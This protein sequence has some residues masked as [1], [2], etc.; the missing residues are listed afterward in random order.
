MKLFSKTPAERR[1]VL[2]NQLGE[3]ESQAAQATQQRID[4][5]LAGSDTG[6]AED[7]AL[8]LAARAS[9]LRDALAQ[10]D[11]EI[12]QAELEAAENLRRRQHSDAANIF[13]ARLAEA[14]HLQAQVHDLASAVAP[15]TEFHDRAAV[16]F[17]DGLL[18][19]SADHV[20]RPFA[21]AIE[22]VITTFERAIISLKN[23]DEHADALAMRALANNQ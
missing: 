16:G 20:G 11:R 9:T 17:A 12:A 18:G 6:P 22:A 2:A 4:L 21:H 1:A 19:A 3:A 14:K 15:V 7:Q 5:A 8:R 10:L 23:G 13:A